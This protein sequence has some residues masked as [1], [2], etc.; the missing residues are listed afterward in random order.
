MSNN[1]GIMISV[2]EYE[3]LQNTKKFVEF[4]N[5]YLMKQLEKK[6]IELEDP[7]FKLEFFEEPNDTPDNYGL[8]MLNAGYSIIY[9]FEAGMGLIDLDELLEEWDKMKER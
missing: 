1:E 8:Y 2:E 6:R 5:R 4:F 3:R 7:N 9:D